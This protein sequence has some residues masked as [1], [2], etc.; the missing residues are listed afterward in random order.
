VRQTK[1]AF[2]LVELIIVVL[3]IGIV[4]ALSYA[5]LSSRSQVANLE[6]AVQVLAADV[7]YARSAAVMKRCQTRFILCMDSLCTDLAG[8]GEDPRF[9]AIL[10]RSHGDQASLQSCFNPN[11]VALADDGFEFWDFDLSPKAIPRGVSFEDVY[12]GT[13][14]DSS[15]WLIVENEEP[16][17]NS[18]WFP[19]S[20]SATLPAPVADPDGRSR[21]VAS[22]ITNSRA[23]GNGSILF[24]MG[25]TECDEDCPLYWVLLMDSG[26]TQVRRCNNTGAAGA[27]ASNDCR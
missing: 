2:T 1:K 5:G 15:D 25:L 4:G 26:E 22:P 9:Y 19:T 13:W 7:S 24:Q 27:D 20:P 3:I 16:V 14:L 21:L 6:K 8:D 12:V 18:L 10:R 11:A 17:E 23:E